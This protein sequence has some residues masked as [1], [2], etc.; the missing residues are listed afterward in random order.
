MPTSSPPNPRTERAAEGFSLLE[1]MVV[2]AILSA[3]FGIGIGMFHKLNRPE[4]TAERAVKDAVREARLFARSESAPASVVVRP[5]AGEVRSLGLR[6]VG[7]WHFEDT[8]GTGWPIPATY[9][10]EA[11]VADGSV[12]SGLRLADE[13]ELQIVSPPGSFDSV[14]GFGLDVALRPAGGGR[15]MTILER[16]GSWT[17]DLDS[18]DALRVTLT[19]DEDGGPRRSAFEYPVHL[20][21]DR[22]TQLLVLFDGRSL[23]VEVDGARA[24]DDTVFAEP[25]RLVRNPGVALT[26]GRDVTRYRGLLDEL[27][28]G[29]VLVGQRVELPVEV[30]L[31]GA[32][33]VVHFDALGHLDP[34]WHRVPEEIAFRYGDP[35][36]VLT[37]ELGLLGTVRSVDEPAVR[38][39]G[40]TSG[41]AA[42][43]P[44]EAGEASK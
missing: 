25:K 17:V 13:A 24:A 2:M 12:G 4:R 23:H 1:L 40:G 35:P 21:N 37:V 22:W 6:T 31:L 3:L 20:P 30:E 28:F 36:R 10:P 15:P 41:A 26:S 29:S 32:E 44:S 42:S 18:D 33:R 39:E 9:P 34:A 14:W 8:A 11:L 27:R 38:G 7:N 43:A 16:A 19:L 5:A